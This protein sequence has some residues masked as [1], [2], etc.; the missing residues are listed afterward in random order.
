M[1]RK[2]EITM[3]I[4]FLDT[5][6]GYSKGED[7]YFYKVHNIP[8]PWN[9]AQEICSKDGGNLAIISSTVTRDV[10]RSLVTVGWIGL[11][12]Q[13]QEGRWQTPT[14]EDSSFSWWLPGEPNDTGSREDCA[15]Q[16]AQYAGSYGWN[17]EPCQVSHAFI[18]QIKD[19]ID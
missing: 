15:A 1:H 6:I 18:C 9:Q 11:T 10:I 13:W 17:D 16:Y 14:K 5:P 8:K 2:Y 19:G 12:D 3:K 7:G 4:D